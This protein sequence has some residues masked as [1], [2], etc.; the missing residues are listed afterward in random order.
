MRGEQPRHVL[1]PVQTT[2]RPADD[3]HG[4]MHSSLFRFEQFSKQAVGAYVVALYVL[5]DK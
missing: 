5:R 4:W 3:E 2:T 1:R